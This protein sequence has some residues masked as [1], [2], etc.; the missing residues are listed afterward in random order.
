M[1]QDGGAGL[2][3]GSLVGGGVERTVG[4]S[5]TPTGSDLEAPGAP[6]LRVQDGDKSERRLLRQ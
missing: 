6:I 2:E 1:R 5:S 3:L 4:R